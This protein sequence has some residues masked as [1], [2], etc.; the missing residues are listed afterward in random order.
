M[1]I[2]DIIL[3]IK[4][5]F[6]DNSKRSIKANQNVCLSFLFKGGIVLINL[7]LVPILINFLG[8]EKYGV[9]IAATS[10]IAWMNFFDVGLGNGLRNRL[11]ESL[12]KNDLVLSKK[13]IA[14]SYASLGIISIISI[15]LFEILYPSPS[16]YTS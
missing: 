1:I 10:I 11:S 12:A 13:Y 2:N 16:V 6:F 14:T 9:W 7:L 15:L 3:Y 8:V 4:K 5:T